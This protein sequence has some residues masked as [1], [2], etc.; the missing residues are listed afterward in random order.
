M[1]HWDIP[2]SVAPGIPETKLT[3]YKELGCQSA[4]GSE[5]LLRAPNTHCNR[6]GV[7]QGKHTH[8][9]LSV[10][11]VI[12]IAD[13]NIKRLDHR[14]RHKF[15]HL[16]QGAQDNIEFSHFVPSMLYKW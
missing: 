14:Q 4:E 15:L 9:V 1:P 10:D 13:Q 8:Q 2:L 11:A 16:T 3:L 6:I 12:V 5:L 7:I